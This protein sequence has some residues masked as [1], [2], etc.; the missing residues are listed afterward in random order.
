M[1]SAVAY[2]QRH[3]AEIDVVHALAGYYPSILVALAAETLGIPSV[4][5]IAANG[6][7]IR[8]ESGIRNI[9]RHIRHRAMRKISAFAAISTEIGES[10]RALDIPEERIHLIP[11]GVDTELFNP[12]ESG[13][14]QEPKKRILFC[15]ALVRR[16]RPHLLLS[17]IPYLKENHDI[18]VIFA[19]PAHDK[20]YF[21][22]LKSI[23]S[24]FGIADRVVWSGFVNDMP[25]LLRRD[26][27]S[28]V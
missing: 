12:P 14:Q 17:A 2:L 3:R 19:G 9:H 7:E 22:E 6:T 28:V 11:N 20:P 16:K 10:L 24:N 27:K 21:D 8:S 25:N 13:C 18:E 5:K 26:R 15:G 1:A 23:A 4:V